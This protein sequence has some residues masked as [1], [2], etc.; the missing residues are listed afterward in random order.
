MIK[1]L[2]FFVLCS[3]SVSYVFS[4][5]DTTKL[6]YAEKFDSDAFVEFGS[7][8]THV[9]QSSGMDI[10]LAV[11]WLVNH[12]YYLGAAYSQ[13][14]SVE[15]KVSKIK[16]LE[17]PLS[18]AVNT[19]INYQT[20]GLRFGYILFENQKIVSFSPDLTVGWV[21][22]KLENEIDKIRLNGAYISPALK[23]VFNVSNYFRIGVELNYNTFI[24]K[25]YDSLNDSNAL[26]SIQFSSK[27]INGIG[28]GIFLRVGQF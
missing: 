24:F 25:E 19:K 27:N 13:L 14:A 28:G 9:N 20:A 3:F 4:Q 6:F 18:E 16:F 11:N 2:L 10:D 5:E 22:V 8:I 23:A 21:G 7:R 26:Y 12:K 17:P 1:K 15:K